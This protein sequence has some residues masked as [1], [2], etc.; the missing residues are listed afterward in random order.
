MHID[1]YETRSGAMRLILKTNEG[2]SVDSTDM[3][4]I[5]YD[6]FATFEAWHRRNGNSNS[7]VQAFYDMRQGVQV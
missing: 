7:A 3:N 2:H 6:M 5:D 1:Q 4:D